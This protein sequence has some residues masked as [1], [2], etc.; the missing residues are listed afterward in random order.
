MGMANRTQVES[1]CGSLVSRFY[2]TFPKFLSTTQS[3]N[4]TQ[5]QNTTFTMEDPNE[6]NDPNNKCPNSKSDVNETHDDPMEL[7]ASGAPPRPPTL[8]ELLAIQTPPSR[9]LLPSR[10]PQQ[11]VRTLAQWYDDMM[12]DFVGLESDTHTVDGDEV[13]CPIN[14]SGLYLDRFLQYT[15]Y[16]LN[17]DECFAINGV[18]LRH[19]AVPLPN[20]VIQIVFDSEFMEGGFNPYG[21]GQTEQA[22]TVKDLIDYY[23]EVCTECD[24]LATPEN[25]SMYQIPSFLLNKACD[26]FNHQSTSTQRA[27]NV[28]VPPEF[29]HLL[30]NERSSLNFEKD[31]TVATQMIKDGH[32]NSE[33]LRKLPNLVVRQVQALRE[34][35]NIKP[36][37]K[38][39]PP[40]NR[41]KESR[42]DGRR[43]EKKDAWHQDNKEDQIAEKNRARARL[44]QVQ[45]QSG[46]SVPLRLLS[47]QTAAGAMLNLISPPKTVLTTGKV[48][49]SDQSP[50]SS[51]TTFNNDSTSSQ[52]PAHDTDS[53]S[54][55][56]N[57][58]SP[59]EEQQPQAAPEEEKKM[60]SFGKL[61]NSGK[62]FVFK[63]LWSA[64]DKWSF[65]WKLPHA[66]KIVWFYV[67]WFATGIPHY[68]S[69]K[70]LKYWLD[71]FR[72]RVVNGKLTGLEMSAKMQSIEREF[73]WGFG[74]NDA[75]NG[76]IWRFLLLALIFNSIFVFI[77]KKIKIQRET[78]MSYR[79]LGP[80]PDAP[81]PTEDIETDLDLNIEATEEDD[82]RPD[83][84][85]TLPLQHN[86]NKTSVLETKQEDFV[87][88]V[89]GV[90]VG[91]LEYSRSD[92]QIVVDAES[93]V[94]M[95]HP[96]N[97]M[98]TTPPYS[99]LEKFS[100][101]VGLA[102]AVNLD[103]YDILAHDVMASTVRFA[104]AVCFSERCSRH[105][106][107]IYS[108]FQEGDPMELLPTRRSPRILFRWNLV[109]IDPKF[110]KVPCSMVTAFR[111]N[112]FLA[113]QRLMSLHSSLR[114]LC[115]D[116]I[117]IYVLPWLQLRCPSSL[118]FLLSQTS[119]ILTTFYSELLNVWP[120]LHVL[121]RDASAVGSAS[122]F[123]LG[124]VKTLSLSRRA[125]LI[126]LKPM[127]RTLIFA[128]ARY[129]KALYR[130]L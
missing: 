59:N 6:N 76:N 66:P 38:N 5:P 16:P 55:L 45:Q 17:D 26:E 20:S 9:W 44:N 2:L 118:Q 33:V 49:S 53:N 69:E 119:Q 101:S 52:S 1:C 68:F 85:T 112:S 65:P 42:D 18:P 8:I 100:R 123:V 88:Y 82:R 27:K 36:V 117:T 32:E 57:R 72:N 79:V 15:Q 34:K 35:L 71:F 93:A 127:L 126:V 48:V 121:L 22:K 60:L 83:V 47:K 130:A 89:C 129:L 14:V 107:D 7:E 120:H 61:L 41:Q 24:I 98:V 74:F 128:I 28:E 108:V 73:A 67:A 95:L 40:L 37:V 19:I 62:Q 50:L 31:I 77:S 81:A 29:S 96:K 58:G 21:N 12:N 111:N 106:T 11:R 70:S 91:H 109:P 87:F 103:K 54:P 46:S 116:M 102:S 84:Y 25:L 94:Q 23:F 97:I 63:Y 115:T 124:F 86:T 4:Q 30:R 39:E 78:T 105:H 99:Q 80:M 113:Y 110:S 90:A 114:Q 104:G 64:K 13:I 51:S 75:I 92:N 10:P 122:L 43:Q 125:I 56:S 3:H